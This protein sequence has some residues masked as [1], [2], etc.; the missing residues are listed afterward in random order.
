MNQARNLLKTLLILLW[1]AN[2]ILFSQGGTLELLQTMYPIYGKGFSFPISGFFLF[3]YPFGTD[4]FNIAIPSATIVG[5]RGAPFG[6]PDKPL[7]A[8]NFFIAGIGVEIN[9]AFPLSKRWEVEFS[10][11][12]LWNFPFSRIILETQQVN[13]LLL[14]NK[15]QIG[16][17]NEM[18]IIAVTDYSARINSFPSAFA[19]IKPIYWFNKST[20]GHLRMG[21][22][23][24]FNSR[25]Q[26]SGS[27]LAY[28]TSTGAS[29]Q[30][31][32]QATLPGLWQWIFIS[33]GGGVVF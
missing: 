19:S 26:I 27:Y 12:G 16:V 17:P 20:F 2:Q 33:I 11:G 8:F 22:M 4:R 1:L 18:D 9:M 14:E 10:V 5:M 23:H 6:S 32:F 30:G 24:G 3:G 15:K 7:E 28:S 21:Y 25:L 31:Q 13:N 29:A